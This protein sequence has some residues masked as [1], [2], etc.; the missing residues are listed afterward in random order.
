MLLGNAQLRT[1]LA[2]GIDDYG[3]PSATTTKKW[4]GT[5]SVRVADT[6]VTRP[7]PDALQ[8]YQQ[9]WV[10][11]PARLTA[12][13]GGYLAFAIG[14]VLE[15]DQDG[16]TQRY[17]VNGFRDFGQRNLATPYAVKL[18]CDRLPA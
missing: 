3:V 14:D 2:G 17:R 11:V 1:V 16:A 9:V 13:A 5:V 4:D 7:G 10:W 15:V 6:Y 8:Q 12:E 18:T